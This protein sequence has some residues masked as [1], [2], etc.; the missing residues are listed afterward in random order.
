MAEITTWKQINTVYLLN[1]FLKSSFKSADLS[2]YT[3]VDLSIAALASETASEVPRVA[4][5]VGGAVITGITLQS[6]YIH[7]FC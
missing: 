6:S 7:W 1:I 3:I 2:K 4:M 5:I